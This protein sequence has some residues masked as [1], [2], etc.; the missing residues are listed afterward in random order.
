MYMS[1]A[2]WSSP[3]AALRNLQSVLK[4]WVISLN[5]LCLEKQLPDQKLSWF[6][7]V[8]CRSE[9]FLPCRRGGYFPAALVV[10][11]S[12]A[13]SH[14]RICKQSAW[15]ASKAQIL[16]HFDHLRASAAHGRAAVVSQENELLQR[17][18]FSLAPLNI[19]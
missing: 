7:V 14:P 3:V 2:S 5:H 15:L 12:Q 16:V 10:S 17:K 13:L 4:S 8:T 11:S 1:P 9:I 19:T 6:L 18:A